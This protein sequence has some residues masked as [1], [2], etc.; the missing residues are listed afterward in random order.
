VAE[1]GDR[2]AAGSALMLHAEVDAPELAPTLTL[3]RDGSVAATATGAHLEFEASGTPAVYRVEATLP[4]RRGGGPLA[5][6]LVSNPI[7]IGPAT[8]WAP[9]VPPP[10]AASKT[11][12]RD[13]AH[14]FAVEHSDGSDGAVAVVRAEGGTQLSLRF[15]LGGKL[16][17][18]PFVAFAS[19]APDVGSYTAITFSGRANRPMRVSVQ[20]RASTEQGSGRW[21]KSV[22]LD[23]TARAVT[24]P[25]SEFRPV[26]SGL[27]PD[28]PLASIASLLFV[29][30]SMN[31]ALGSNGE[32]WLDDVTF[33]R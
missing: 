21:R 16:S 10:P 6:W 11:V 27:A 28:P 2:V 23:E 24:L 26:Q 22:Y 7:Y 8:P 31:T 15:A 32:F 1:A 29:L 4:V 9:T 33:V 19:A 17:D 20:L 5:P 13:G 3:Y 14:E 25:F 30:D 12:Y 18:A